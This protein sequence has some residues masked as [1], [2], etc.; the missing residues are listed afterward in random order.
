V[1]L[2]AGARADMQTLGYTFSDARRDKG[3]NG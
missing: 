1:A 2:L 3:S